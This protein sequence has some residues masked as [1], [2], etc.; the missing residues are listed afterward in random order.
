VDLW[1]NGQAEREEGHWAYE[2]IMK[3]VIMQHDSEREED[4]MPCFNNMSYA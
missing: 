2:V 1:H 3:W 4:H